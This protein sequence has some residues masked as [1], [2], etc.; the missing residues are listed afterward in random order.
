MRSARTQ[1]FYERN[2]SHM[3]RQA[4]LGRGDGG[5]ASKL[6]CFRRHHLSLTHVLRPGTVGVYR[7]AIK[8]VMEDF[9]R[10][11]LDEGAVETARNEIL[12]ALD[13]RMGT[14]AEPRTSSLKIEVPR[15]SSVEKTFELLRRRTLKRAK[16]AE[17]EGEVIAEGKN[18]LDIILLLY[19]LCAPRLGIRPI[20]LLGARR[21]EGSLIVRTAKQAG[22]PERSIPLL[23]WSDQHLAALDLLLALVPHKIEDENYVKWRNAL[24]SKLARASLKACGMRLSLYFGRHTAIA[25]WRELGLTREQIKLLAGHLGLKSQSVYGRGSSGYIHQWV[26]DNERRAAADLLVRAV[27]QDAEIQGRRRSVSDE[28]GEMIEEADRFFPKHTGREPKPDAEGAALWT[29]YVSKLDTMTEQS[30]RSADNIIKKGRR[31]GRD[32]PKR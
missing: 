4:H 18:R 23:G 17:A 20:E 7:Q 28:I 5:A 26:S 1:T 3:Y 21:Q 31:F 19:L 30:K 9:Y 8:L 10:C 27:D 25:R 16:K 12:F 15:F 14:P 22:N 32:G 2:A 11:G 6:E 29:K 24:A 13:E